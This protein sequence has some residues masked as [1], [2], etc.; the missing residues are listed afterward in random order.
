MSWSVCN[1]ENLIIGSNFSSSTTF[2]IS[3][4]DELLF[5][6]VEVGIG[7]LQSLELS[8]PSL[9]MWC[10]NSSV[11][12][13]RN[14]F[15]FVCFNKRTFSIVLA[16]DPFHCL[17]KLVL[18]ENMNCMKEFS[19]GIQQQEHF[20]TIALSVHQ[21]CLCWKLEE[22]ESSRHKQSRV[23]FVREMKNLVQ[24]LESLQRMWEKQMRM[25]PEFDIIHAVLWES[26]VVGHNSAS[27][28][29]MVHN[30][31]QCWPLLTTCNKDYP[32]LWWTWTHIISYMVCRVFKQTEN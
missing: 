29:T 9:W 5:T 16:L 4:S 8:N 20:T 21:G 18:I 11:V 13:T 28:M 7:E 12:Q 22:V 19:R 1:L 24:I 30:A 2:G 10:L 6:P 3:L 25:L 23:A 27:L 17:W 14:R 15:N 32:P 26:R 31:W